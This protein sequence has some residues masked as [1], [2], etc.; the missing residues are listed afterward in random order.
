MAA[1][2]AGAGKADRTSGQERMVPGR[3]R[4]KNSNTLTEVRI[5]APATMAR[6][7]TQTEQSLKRPDWKN[8]KVLLQISQN[9]D[10]LFM[11]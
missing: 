2:A 1:D 10:F 11:A 9:A 3:V 4:Q 7:R 6:V 8:F 5:G